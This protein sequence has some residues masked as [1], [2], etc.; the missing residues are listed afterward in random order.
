[1]GRNTWDLKQVK[2]LRLSRHWSQEQ[3]AESSGLS[4][5]TIQRIEKGHKVDIG[6]IKLLADTF[7]LEINDLLGDSSEFPGLDEGFRKEPQK[8]MY[9]YLALLSAVILIALRLYMVNLR[10]TAD[11]SVNVDIWVSFFTSV[12]ATLLLLA[13][14]A[15]KSLGRGVSRRFVNRVLRG[16]YLSEK[17][18]LLPVSRSKREFMDVL[19]IVSLSAVSMFA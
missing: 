16:N 11:A 5:R 15:E 8:V 9:F 3:L 10:L 6:S 18:L 2:S 19:I 7:G 14:I 1:M 17:P 13:F 4:T 12:V